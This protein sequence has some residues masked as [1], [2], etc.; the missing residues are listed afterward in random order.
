MRWRLDVVKS[1]G[2]SLQSTGVVGFKVGQRSG[3]ALKVEA[4]TRQAT[5][6]VVRCDRAHTP[7]PRAMVSF[8]EAGM[9]LSLLSSLASASNMLAVAL[10]RS[11]LVLRPVTYAVR[12][13]SRSNLRNETSHHVELRVAECFERAVE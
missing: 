12:A 2:R 8:C 6:A 10:L 4:A 5:S 11:P 1:G 9:P 3:N 7:W 13:A